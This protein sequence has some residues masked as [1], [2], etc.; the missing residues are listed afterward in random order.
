MK[1]EVYVRLSKPQRRFPFLIIPAHIA[2]FE[3]FIGMHI[4]SHELGFLRRPY[5]GHYKTIE[6]TANQDHLSRCLE[7]CKRFF[8]YLLSV[9]EF[10]YANFTAFQWSLMVQATVVLSR[11]TF[12]MASNLGWD[13]ETTRSHVPL[14]MYLDALCFRF[15]SLSMVSSLGTSTPENPDILYVFKMIISSV[16]KSY[17]CRVSDIQPN[18]FAAERGNGIGIAR[19]QCPISDPSL[20]IYLDSDDSSYGGSW[21]L[22]GGTVNTPSTNCT[23]GVPLYHDLW[24]TMTGTW[25]EDI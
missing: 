23:A 17:E 8:E 18:F 2:L 15:Q 3:R 13:P 14:V 1:S 10:H 7:A 6:S 19:G 21:N 5:R 11:L 24:A 25:A 22:S 9:P 20:S 16:K 4:Y 12:V